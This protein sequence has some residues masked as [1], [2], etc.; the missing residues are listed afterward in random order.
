[1]NSHTFGNRPSGHFWS[2]RRE[3]AVIDQWRCENPDCDD[4]SRIL[5]T[6]SVVPSSVPKCHRCEEPL[7]QVVGEEQLQFSR[8]GG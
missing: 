6:R 3:E 1:M 2:Q 4:N 8:G 7:T 5:K